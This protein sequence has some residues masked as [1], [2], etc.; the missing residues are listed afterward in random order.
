[1]LD[2]HA[3]HCLAGFLTIKPASVCRAGVVPLKAQLTKLHDQEA[4][5]QQQLETR[6]ARLKD[7]AVGHDQ[8]PSA[9][10]FVPSSCTQ[11]HSMW[12]QSVCVLWHCLLQT[13]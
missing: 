3:H 4:S 2:C 1:M 10:S 13:C 7:I 8:L 6:E 12:V 9:G 5:H 11:Q